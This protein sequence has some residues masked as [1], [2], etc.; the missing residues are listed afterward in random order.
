MYKL[1]KTYFAG[2]SLSYSVKYIVDVK[3]T[4]CL[5]AVNRH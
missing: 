5:Y 3:N 4:Y 2:L 1:L